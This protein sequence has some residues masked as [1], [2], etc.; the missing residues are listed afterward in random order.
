[1]NR[2]LI[3]LLI[4]VAAV[5]CKEEAGSRLDNQIRVTYTG[6]PYEA[7][8][9]W[10]GKADTINMVRNVSEFRLPV[11]ENFKYQNINSSGRLNVYV[12]GHMQDEAVQ[13]SP[14]DLEE[15]VYEIQ[16]DN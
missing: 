14:E 9:I 8:I 10:P 4:A 2:F 1:M 7:R 5:G 6:G 16:Y 15:H 13:L 11:G 12:N 3:V